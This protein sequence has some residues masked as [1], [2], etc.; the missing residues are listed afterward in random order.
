MVIDQNRGNQAEPCYPVFNLLFNDRR[1]TGDFRIDPGLRKSHQDGDSILLPQRVLKKK[2]RNLRPGRSW[3]QSIFR[4]L[5]VDRLNANPRTIP[6]GIA[7]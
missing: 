2:G 5:L 4:L 7:G 3:G 1:S 6:V